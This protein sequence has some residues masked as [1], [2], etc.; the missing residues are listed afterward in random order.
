MVDIVRAYDLVADSGA[1]SDEEKR[2]VENDLL[3]ASLACFKSDDFQNDVRIRDLH[4]RCYNF[5]A[6]HLAAIG[7]VGLAVQD[8]DLVDYAA[9]SPYGL[10]H[11]IAHDIRD[12]GLF[13]ER[14][15]GYHQFVVMALVPFTEA[16][17][18]CGVNLYGVQVPTDRGR[19]EDAH[20][21]TDTSDEPKSLRLLF[22]SPLYL[23]F[24][25]LSYPA[26]G[27]SDRGPLRGTW[28]QLV[29]FH[30]YG[31]PKLAWLMQ[32]DMPIG[33]T[34]TNRGHV[35]LLHYYRYHYRYDDLLLNGRPIAWQKR[36]ET[37]NANLKDR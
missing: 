19:D 15:V 16:M 35:G 31:D 2:R 23:A 17:A 28:Q 27:D 37:Y 4:Y 21:L 10:R 12:D 5:P 34:R 22:N 7:L 33:V 29:G 20:Y 6:W 14:S 26:L 9:H 1:F 3:R 36:A 30:R 18:H 11:L 8:A 25:D 24:P 32:R 13:W